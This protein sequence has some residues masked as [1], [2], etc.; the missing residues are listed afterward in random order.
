MKIVAVALKS[1]QG[2]IFTLPAPA[3]HGHVISY[4]NYDQIKEHPLTAEQGFLTDEGQF[5]NRKQAMYVA[6]EA[7]QILEHMEHKL[8][9]NELYSKHLW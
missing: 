4:M 2:L 8:P 6:T 5:I 7:N 1:K 9:K 3:R